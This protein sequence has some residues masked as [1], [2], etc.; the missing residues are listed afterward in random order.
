M[1]EDNVALVRRSIDA[2]RHG[3]LEGVLGTFAPEFEFEPSG[4][5][6]DMPRVYRGRE[7]WIEFWNTF[8]PAWDDVVIQIERMEDLEDRVLTLGR[9]GGR[10]GES[11]VEVDAKAA[12]LHT[13][14]DGRI[15]HLRSFTTWADARAAAEETTH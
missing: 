13:V 3:D 10:G 6:M 5:F 1:S 12:W 15:V 9:L 7:G 2:F 14:R 8:R 11:G 4:R